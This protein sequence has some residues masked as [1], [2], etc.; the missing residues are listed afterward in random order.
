MLQKLLTL[1]ML[2]SSLSLISQNSQGDFKLSQDGYWDKYY[3]WQ[4]YDSGTW[5]DAVIGETPNSSSNVNIPIGLKVTIVQ[6]NLW[7]NDLEISGTLEIASPDRLNTLNQLT[8]NG[9]T[10]VLEQAK[11]IGNGVN[12]NNSNLI[13][14]GNLSNLGSILSKNTDRY[15]NEV[16]YSV[17]FKGEKAIEISGSGEFD[18]N[19]VVIYKDN[20]VNT[21]TQKVS[22]G[23]VG[24]FNFVKGTFIIDGSFTQSIFKDDNSVDIIGDK[25][26]LIVNNINS[27]L[28]LPDAVRVYGSLVCNEGKISIGDNATEGAKIDY[29][30][31]SIIVGGGNI[32]I[33]GNVDVSYGNLEINKG[34]LDIQTAGE[35]VSINSVHISEN[36]SLNLNGGKMTVHNGSQLKNILFVDKLASSNLSSNI[37]FKNNSNL[38]N[39]RISA[40]VVFNVVDFSIG[41]S[42]VLIIEDSEISFREGILSNSKN[43]KILN[44]SVEINNNLDKLPLLETNYNTTLKLVSNQNISIPNLFISGKQTIGNLVID[45]PNGSIDIIEDIYFSNEAISGYF[46]LISGGVNIKNNAN[47]IIEGII[48]NTS[49]EFRVKDGSCIFQL[50]NSVSNIGDIIVERNEIINSYN[51]NYWSSPVDSDEFRPINVWDF[52]ESEG[53]YDESELQELLGTWNNVDINSEINRGR[54]LE[55]P[56]PNNSDPNTLFFVGK[57]NNGTVNI[58]VVFNESGY[59]LVGNPYP[60]SLDYIEFLKTNNKELVQGIYSWSHNESSNKQ[61]ITS[62]LLGSVPASSLENNKIKVSQGFIV[63]LAG[64]ANKTIVFNNDQRLTVDQANAKRA[65]YNG[66]KLWL[67]LN[68]NDES[69]ELMIAAFDGASNDEDDYDVSKLDLYGSMS[70]ST[71]ISEKEYKI[72]SLNL[73]TDEHIL[74]LNIEAEE[75]GIY[76]ISKVK[77]ENDLVDLKVQ[78]HDK[79]SGA[80]TNLLTSTYEFNISNTGTISDRFELIISHIGQ[81]SE[82]SKITYD[83]KLITTDNELTL[84]SSD[85]DFTAVKIISLDGKSQDLRMIREV[86]NE[87]VYDISELNKGVYIIYAITNDGRELSRKI[88]I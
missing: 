16:F 67:S 55:V 32:D 14:R 70:V 4:I 58:D 22:L 21:V 42:S 3:V 80:V 15:G 87:S 33:K 43:I 28:I 40:N 12:G 24:N 5:R 74:P 45:L 71:L 41:S 77:L 68:R 11:I 85:T 81:L 47:I 29:F 17:M 1:V 27:E 82:E 84:T 39:I 25:V 31:A 64:E 8:V 19:E 56:G 46:E 49:G 35:Q 53:E 34:N 23:N 66:Y 76:S 26:V 51:H 65:N 60:S 69:N 2:I 20:T 13:F 73:E 61:L 38:D 7:C 30:T 75:T 83:F 86:K 37:L 62:G 9:D 6:Q 36:G 57:P 63:K 72:H 48:S 50:N 59:N 52:G 10:K 79:Q 44:S 78:L 54:G 18:L 88:L